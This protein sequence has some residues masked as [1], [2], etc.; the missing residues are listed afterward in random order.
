MVN[1]DGGVMTEIK[2]RPRAADD[3]SAYRSIMVQN[4]C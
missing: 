3:T 1:S 4:S 2:T